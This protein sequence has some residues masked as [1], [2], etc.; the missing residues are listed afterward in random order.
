M[1]PK[2]DSELVDG[3][4][5]RQVPSTTIPLAGFAGPFPPPPAE[6]PAELAAAYVELWRSP[7]AA[8]W[9]PSES[10]L[11][12]ELVELRGLCAAARRRGEFPPGTAQARIGVIEDR[13][14]LHPKGRAMQRL[15]VVDEPVSEPASSSTRTARSDRIRDALAEKGIVVE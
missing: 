9:L 11:V 10:E 3:R 15:R 5:A 14:A 7:Q 1:I 13:L 12:V 4:K 2:Q 6:L 8:A